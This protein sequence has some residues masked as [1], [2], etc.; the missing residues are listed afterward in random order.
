MDGTLIAVL[1]GLGVIVL[2]ALVVAAVLKQRRGDSQRAEQRRAEADQH[3]RESEFRAAQ[4]DE[5]Q[6]QADVRAARARQEA[7]AAEAESARAQEV[8]AQA[9]TARDQARKLDP[10]SSDRDGDRSDLARHDRR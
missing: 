1:I 10:R 5:L 8:R 6:A 9:D 7:A 4:A 2:I 3:R